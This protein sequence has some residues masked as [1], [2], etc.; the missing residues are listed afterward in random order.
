MIVNEERFNRLIADAL[1]QD[2][3]GWDF[4]S[5]MGTGKQKS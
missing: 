4:S 5:W 2:I 3:S 1:A